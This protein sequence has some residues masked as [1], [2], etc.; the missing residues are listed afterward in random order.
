MYLSIVQNSPM[1]R[2]NS[3]RCSPSTGSPGS[4]KSS[5][6]TTPGKWQGAAFLR[7]VAPTIYTKSWPVM[8][9][10]SPICRRTVR[11]HPDGSLDQI[12]SIALASSRAAKIDRPS[13][14]VPDQRPGLADRQNREGTQ[15][16]KTFHFESWTA[17]RPT[18]LASS[19]PTTSPNTPTH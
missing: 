11:D 4:P 6:T 3:S 19:S 5:S 9:W 13:L 16:S 17:S 14:I 7:N 15:P 10:S 12:S 2:A 8:A 18:C 1:P